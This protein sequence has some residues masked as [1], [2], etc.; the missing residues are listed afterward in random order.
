MKSLFLSILGLS[1]KSSYI[2]LI[3]FAIR[4]LIKEAPKIYSYIL[5]V[6]V[7]IRLALL[8]SIPS[9]YSLFNYVEKRD[10]VTN[11]E[12]NIVGAIEIGQFNNGVDIAEQVENI[13]GISNISK[14]A[15]IGIWDIASIIWIVGMIAI[16]IYSIY[17][18]IKL[19]RKL[20]FSVLQKDNIY[21]CEN[22]ESPFV[23]GFIKPK[24]YFPS[25]MELEGN[26]YIL[27][28][29]KIHIERYD[30][31][32]KPIC[33]VI[34][35][36]HWFNPLVWLSYYLLVKDMEM[37]C[38]EEVLNRFTG[39]I[40]ADY[41]KNIVELAT[42][43]NNYFIVPIAF[44]QS[45]VKDRIKNI[46]KYKKYSRIAGICFAVLLV[47]VGCTILPSSK[48]ESYTEPFN[49]KNHNFVYGDG[50]DKYSNDEYVKGRQKY[51]KQYDD[52][53]DNLYK[54][55]T[56]FEETNI[57]SSTPGKEKLEN[58]KQLLFIPNKVN[59]NNITAFV[60]NGEN[61]ISLEYA[62]T[63]VS[64]Y[65]R[66]SYESEY[67]EYYI[68]LNSDFGKLVADTLFVTVDDVDKVIINYKY[69]D[70]VD[71]REFIP[72]NTEIFEDNVDEDR[73][74]EY[75][76]QVNYIEQVGY[77]IEEQLVIND[78]NIRGNNETDAYH[79]IFRDFNFEDKLKE[80][81]HESASGSWEGSQLGI[82]TEIVDG[83]DYK[84]FNELEYFSTT[85]TKSGKEEEY[86]GTDIVMVKV[87]FTGRPGEYEYIK[88]I[89]Y[90]VEDITKEN[91]EE[92]F[93]KG[94]YEKH[95]DKIKTRK[96][97]DKEQKELME[98]SRKYN[99]NK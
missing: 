26:K 99:K 87:V 66:P 37:S 73:F 48:E 92:F 49:G 5:M 52:V 14:V 80:I 12:N 15:T 57:D 79:G 61:I 58:L 42:G 40:K 55:R 91:F 76:D 36:V 62:L 50:N 35:I 34:L 45:G 70:T 8:K 88:T 17:S 39:E 27:E 9:I 4:F 38:D 44:S 6:L 67:D 21:L 13:E 16:L 84:N 60:E 68:A 97:I 31:I 77:I 94:E 1:I 22:I 93:G 54:N 18:Y 86:L 82:K 85:I 7:F 19:K 47:I 83:V 11:Y 72:E 20:E 25:F 81:E 95:K 30:Y 75:I 64:K 32:I 28:H 71:K 29:E 96:E 23:L 2:I 46:L 56:K 59:L 51:R 33:F 43:K 41:S 98:H 10:I 69:N 63:D 53:I 3:I 89:R 90:L 65:L 74:V 24:I 78:N